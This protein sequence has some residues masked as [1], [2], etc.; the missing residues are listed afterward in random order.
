MSHSESLRM[1]S[2]R[3]GSWDGASA[4]RN[5]SHSIFRCKAVGLGSCCPHHASSSPGQPSC[6]S[7]VVG[8][9]ETHKGQLRPPGPPHGIGSETGICRAGQSL[10]PRAAGLRCAPILILARQAPIRGYTWKP[11]G[12]LCRQVQNAVRPGMEGHLGHLLPMDPPG[13]SAAKRIG[14]REAGQRGQQRGTGGGDRLAF[15]TRTFSVVTKAWRRPA[16]P[17]PPT[18]SALYRVKVSGKQAAEPAPPV[19]SDALPLAAVFRKGK[20]KSPYSCRRVSTLRPPPSLLHK[21]HALR[22]AVHTGRYDGHG[23]E[24]FWGS[25]VASLW[26]GILGQAKP[27]PMTPSGASKP[28][29]HEAGANPG[30]SRHPANT[31]LFIFTRWDF[32]PWHRPHFGGDGTLP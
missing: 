21:I 29:S 30:W 16:A 17:A 24:Q 15:P 9:T 28:S 1:A 13:P 19:L 4:T 11:P 25:M 3:H 2:A 8:I 31:P 14:G 23:S 20:R 22:S 12:F 26:P 32:W 27:E 5:A 18:P 7:S 6:M 10:P